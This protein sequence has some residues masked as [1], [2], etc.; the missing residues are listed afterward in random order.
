MVLITVYTEIKENDQDIPT[1][2]RTQ[3]YKD[4]VNNEMM[5]DGKVL[6]TDKIVAIYK[7]VDKMLYAT[8]KAT[9]LKK[10]TKTF[11]TPFPLWT[12]NN[13]IKIKVHLENNNGI[14]DNTYE[15]V[16][17]TAD[18]IT[19]VTFVIKPEPVIKTEPVIEPEP[20]IIDDDED[21]IPEGFQE[22]S[23]DDVPCASTITTAPKTAA[24]KQQP[25]NDAKTKKAN[26]EQLAK[27]K[28]QELKAQKEAEEKAQKEAEEQLAKQ[29][30][31]ELQAQKEAE[32]KA[33]K[34]AEEQLAKQKAQELQAKKEAEEKLAKKRA[35]IVEVIKTTKDKVDLLNKQINVLQMDEYKKLYELASTYDAPPEKGIATLIKPMCTTT[36][37]APF[38]VMRSDKKYLPV[39]QIF[40]I[41]AQLSYQ[42]QGKAIN[43]ANIAS[44]MQGYYKYWAEDNKDLAQTFKAEAEKWNNENKYAKVTAK[45]G[46][47]TVTAAKVANNIETDHFAEAFGTDTVKPSRKRAA[48]G[49]AG[50]MQ[51]KRK[52][53]SEDKSKAD[54][55][56]KLFS[57]S[58]DEK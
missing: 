52:S 36:T 15:E 43:N 27:Q 33:Q 55:E 10:G 12:G 5:F 54:S 56:E 24:T 1:Q 29:K 53:D 58:S 41:M 32:E 35:E 21:E 11:V 17:Y 4:I 48:G 37:N 46:K 14:P 6:P 22:E 57:D 16:N 26:E 19:I 40:E 42:I 34:E 18:G 23:D 2:A 20:V 28:E 45:V 30:A 38:N 13:N 3:V 51:K 50:K 25:A 49:S 9:V 7:P 8:H 31:Q 39:L 44:V 47:A